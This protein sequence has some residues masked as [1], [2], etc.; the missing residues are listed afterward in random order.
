MNWNASRGLP[1]ILGLAGLAL[2]LFTVQASASPYKGR[3]SLNGPAQW[4]DVLLGPGT[5]EF[6]LPSTGFPY[7]V[8][9]RGEGQNAVFFST[10]TELSAGERAEMG[11]AQLKLER[12]NGIPVVRTLIIPELGAAFHFALPKHANSVNPA[13][14]PVGKGGCSG[15][16]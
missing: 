11:D 12:V 16:L 8:N 9:V 13:P 5:Y 15:K 10:M 7:Q 6:S 1:R 4:G 14:V 3:F 2:I